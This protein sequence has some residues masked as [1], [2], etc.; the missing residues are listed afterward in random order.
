M[1]EQLFCGSH[2][3]RFGTAISNPAATVLVEHNAH[4]KT[5]SAQQVEKLT[6]AACPEP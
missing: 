2:N 1:V 4:Y 6:D 5:S 3:S